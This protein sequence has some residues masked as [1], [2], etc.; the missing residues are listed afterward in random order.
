MESSMRTSV[1][2]SSPSSPPAAPSGSASRS[3]SVGYSAAITSALAGPVVAFARFGASSPAPTAYTARCNAPRTVAS[4]V[5]I[6]PDPVCDRSRCSLMR[7]H[8]VWSIS[9]TEC[10]Q[11]RHPSCH[12]RR[13]TRCP[14][15][16]HFRTPVSLLK[17][18][19]TR[20]IQRAPLLARVYN[21]LPAVS[22]RSTSFLTI[23]RVAGMEPGA[24]YP[25]RELWTVS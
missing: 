9:R 8:A 22:R 1:A 20:G 13:G 23:G 25:Y 7:H 16:G 14:T 12:I 5:D 17:T 11:L 2:S 3:L 4:G 15:R 6:R 24:R 10:R 18:H 21:R 19:S